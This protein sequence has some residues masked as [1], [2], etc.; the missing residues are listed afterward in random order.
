MAAHASSI[1]PAPITQW[2]LRAGQSGLVQPLPEIHHKAR[3]CDL[4]NVILVV[5]EAGAHLTDAYLGCLVRDNLHWHSI[6]ASPLTRS[7]AA[8]TPRL[9]IPCEKKTFVIIFCPTGCLSPSVADSAVN[10]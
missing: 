6:V 5:Q 8:M 1:D 2:E 10:F 4:S 7:A 3:A 9:S